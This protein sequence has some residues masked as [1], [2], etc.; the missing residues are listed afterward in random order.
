MVYRLS[1]ICFPCYFV[2]NVLESTWSNIANMF[3][4]I[5][6]EKAVPIDLL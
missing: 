5:K 6:L 4:F 2:S 1:I 3:K